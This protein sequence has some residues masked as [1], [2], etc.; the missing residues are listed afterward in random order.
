MTMRTPPALKKLL[1]LPKLQLGVYETHV[2]AVNRFNGL[3]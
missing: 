3:S 2:E 1:I